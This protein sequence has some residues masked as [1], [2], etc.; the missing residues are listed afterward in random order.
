MIPHDPSEHVDSMPGVGDLIGGRYRLESI[1]GHGALG[2]VMRAQHITMGRDVAV[3]LLRP[4]ISNHRSIRRRLIQ[5]VHQAQ[6]LHHPNNCRLLDFGQADGSLY[7]V[8]ELLEG[9]SLQTIIEHGAPYPV[10]WVLDIGSQILDGLGEAHDH[11][12]VHRNLKPRNIYLLPRRRGGQH[13]KIVDYGLA[14]SLD[15]LPGGDDDDREAEICGTA[16]YLAPETLVQHRSGKSTDVYAVGLILLEMLTGRQVFDGESL[17]Q[18]LYRQIHTSVHMPA[19]LAWTSLGKA[20]LKAVSKHPD[21][22]YA[23]AD[24]FYEAL[25]QASQ[26]TASYFRLDPRD[27]EP[28]VDQLPP[29]LL[30]RMMRNQRSRR[31]SDRG[32]DEADDDAEPERV[33]G[34]ARADGPEAGTSKPVDDAAE[35]FR[36]I[37]PPF[38]MPAEPARP[39]RSARL[40]APST[41]RYAPRPGQPGRLDGAEFGARRPTHPLAA[42]GSDAAASPHKPFP[43]GS[44]SLGDGQARGAP[45]SGKG[46]PRLSLRDEWWRRGAW[47]HV[48]QDGWASRATV[49]LVALL[50]SLAGLGLYLTLAAG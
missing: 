18:V 34:R 16:A 15:S 32:G 50:V 2:T 43:R 31:D 28:E 22:R 9:A 49:V 1:I 25:E 21:N 40:G 47:L 45:A 42:A 3:K 13:V 27:I 37:P 35:T 23:D 38:P 6:L 30:A 8:M 12:F 7:L 48:G 4:D 20:L 46:P 41:Q 14:S 26:S 39:E 10:G 17:S 5:R 29:E 11:D 19:K 44:H 24:A 33:G 36:L